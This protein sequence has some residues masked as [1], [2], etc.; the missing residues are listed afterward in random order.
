MASYERFTAA[1]VREVLRLAAELLPQRIP[2][3]RVAENSHSITLR[4]ED[5]T[6][7]IEA[8]RHGVETA[9]H[10]TTDQLRTSRIDIET[11]Y[12]LN[13]LPY[14]PGDVPTR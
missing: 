1:S 11:Q 5:G 10:A 9:V 3:Q 7:T 14:Q 6:V 4:G 8:H 12:Y 13:Q 2:L